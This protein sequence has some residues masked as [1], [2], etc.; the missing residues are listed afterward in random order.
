[1]LSLEFVQALSAQPGN[2]RVPVKPDYPYR[3]RLQLPKGWDHKHKLMQVIIGILPATIDELKDRDF[4]QGGTTSYYVTH[5]I[6]SIT[7]ANIQT[8]PPVEINFR[9]HYTVSFDY[10][11]YCALAVYDSLMQPITKLRLIAGDEFFRYTN[12]FSTPAQDIAYRTQY[13]YDSRGRPIGRT[14]VQEGRG[15]NTY[16]PKV[17]PWQILTPVFLENICKRK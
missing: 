3:Y 4:S 17:N 11:L 6:D 9:P 5:L 8:P 1:M 7:V 15:V 14:Y 16:M 10:S 2:K 12:M 13:V